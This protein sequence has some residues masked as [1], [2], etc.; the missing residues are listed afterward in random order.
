MGRGGLGEMGSKEKISSVRAGVG[1]GPVG[2][3]ESRDV[4]GFLTVEDTHEAASRLWTRGP[5][6]VLPP[7]A[8][9][10]ALAFPAVA[11]LSGDKPGDVTGS[12]AAAFKLKK[13]FHPCSEIPHPLRKPRVLWIPV[14][15][16][17]LGTASVKCVVDSLG[18]FRG[19]LV[20][21]LGSHP[22]RHIDLRSS[23]DFGKET[24]VRPVPRARRGNVLK[25]DRKAKHQ[26]CGPIH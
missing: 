7:Q 1:R 24:L 3:K 5:L 6:H 13:V 12:G 2:F 23:K 16:L 19:H 22:G 17:G 15:A 9:T 4:L 10:T 20:Q 25:A 14:M 18:Q 21:F 26:C 8:A 11:V